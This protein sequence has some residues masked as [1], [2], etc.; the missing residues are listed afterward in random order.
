M[1]WHRENTGNPNVLCHPSDGKAWKYFDEVYPDYASDIRNVRLGLCSDGFTP[2]IQAS[3]SMYS[4]WMMIVTPYNLSPEM[5]MTKPYMFL[6]CLVHRPYKPKVK[7][8]VYLQ[9]LIDGL[10]RLWIDGIVAYNVSMK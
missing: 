5:C 9:P 7:I 8:D 1:R 2:Y 4:C 3:S 6:T 10:Q